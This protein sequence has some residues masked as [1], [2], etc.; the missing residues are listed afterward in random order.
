MS[1]S[2]KSVRSSSTGGATVSIPARYSIDGSRSSLRA[3]SAPQWLATPVITTR[4]PDDT[5]ILGFRFRLWGG[6]KCVLQIGESPLQS[7]ESLGQLVAGPL[8]P[9]RQPGARFGAATSQLLARVLAAS[10]ELAA[11]L[12][13]TPRDLVEQLGGA[14]GAKRGRSRAGPL[15]G[16]RQGALDRRAQRLRDATVTRSP[17]FLRH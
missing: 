13:P 1:A 3:S 17:R 12:L 4:R 14:L 15:A 7:F 9:T 8:P 11:G 6:P 2:I 10:G 5:L 16:H